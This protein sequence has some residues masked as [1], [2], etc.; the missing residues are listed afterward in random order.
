MEKAENLRLEAAEHRAVIAA[1]APSFDGAPDGIDAL[2]TNEEELMQ[3]VREKLHVPALC[4]VLDTL[5][6]R[7]Q[8][9]HSRLRPLLPD[10]RKCGF[11]GRAR[12]FRW[13]PTESIVEDDPY[14]P[15]IEAVDSLR[16][17][18]VVVHSTDTTLSSA[19]WGELLTTVAM[20]NGA[21]GCV[22]DAAVRD[23]VRIIEMGF[24]VFYA[25]INPLD[26]KGRCR[27]MDYDVPVICGGISVHPGEIVVADHDGIV[28]IPHAAEKVALSMAYDKIQC[29]SETRKDLQNGHRL[30]DVYDRY[31]VL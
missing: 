31:G 12:T 20:R 4:D 13:V 3:F 1:R 28:V 19:P 23:T 5:G 22:C 29:E 26:S 21:V 17:G 14:G 2:L 25:G 9:M 10:I 24:P 18:D 11:A 8:A 7:S 27:V 30:R 16:P 15:E 6:L